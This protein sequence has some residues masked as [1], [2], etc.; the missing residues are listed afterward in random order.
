M[1]LSKHEMPSGYDQGQKWEVKLEEFLQFDVLPLTFD[2]EPERDSCLCEIVW[3]DLYF[4]VI[5]REHANAI[6][7][8]FACQMAN[9][10]LVVFKFHPETSCR[11]GLKDLTAHLN[12]LFF[13]HN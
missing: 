12:E 1:I 9:D 6:F 11:Q 3:R 13:R 2:L 10:F 5:A 8:Q 4:D 7:S